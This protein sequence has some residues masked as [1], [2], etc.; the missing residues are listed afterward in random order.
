MHRRSAPRGPTWALDL[1]PLSNG[2]RPPA[3]D[4]PLGR[5]LPQ[6][7]YP[8]P[9]CRGTAEQPGLSSCPAAPPGFHPHPG[10]ATLPSCPTRCSRRST[11]ALPRSVPDSLAGAGE[12]CVCRPSGAHRMTLTPP[13]SSL[14]LMPPGSCMP[15]EPKPKRKAVV[16]PE[17]DGHSHF[18]IMQAAAKHHE[19][20][21]SRHTCAPH[22]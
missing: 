8:D 9:G 18:V 7:D 14:E 1:L 17:K 2:H 21:S 15:E 13:S 22:R 10:P 11:A 6:Q 12:P 20:F 3:H 16:A 5:Q 4:F 19:E